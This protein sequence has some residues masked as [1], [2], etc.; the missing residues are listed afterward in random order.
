MSP[1][2]R[3]RGR[4]ACVDAP[5]DVGVEAESRREG[6][7]AAVQRPERDRAGA[8]GERRLAH[9]LGRGAHLVRQ[10]QR[11]RQHAG[12]AGRQQPDGDLDADPVQHVVRRAVAGE[13][14]DGV[15]AEVDRLAGQL[16]RLPGAL[17]R[18]DLDAARLECE[19]RLLERAGVR[20]GRDRVHDEP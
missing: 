12:S 15:V 17:R 14:D 13:H 11:A 20:P 3:P 5:H 6:E 10:A 16:A 9:H 1:G 4:P 2:R 19:H 7:A 18:H 8:V